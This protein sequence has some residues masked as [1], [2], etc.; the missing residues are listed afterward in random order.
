MRLGQVANRATRLTVGVLAAV[1]LALLVVPI[2]ALVLRAL[3][4]RGS[5][6][7]LLSQPLA[8]AVLLS[9]I[10]TSLSALLIVALG[11]PLAYVFARYRFPLKRVLN[12]LIEVPVVMPPV[13]AGLALLMTFGRRGVLGG[14]LAG[15][16]VSLPFSAAAVVIAQV[17]V[18]S[19]FFI[20]AAQVE[21]QSIPR[22]L[23]EAASIDGATGVQ[24][25]LHVI[26]PLS[27]RGLLVGLVLSWARAL[28][29]FGATILFAG[30]LQGR[31]QTMPLFVYGAM[32]RDLNAA[33]WASVMLIGVAVMALGV[34]RWL[35][36]SLEEPEGSTSRGS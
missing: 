26:L 36:R 7:A 17:F 16:G 25:F 6:P 35:S 27:A 32:E 3:A 28:G 19:P 33:L 30:N 5:L 10:T 11:M 24:T 15:A 14:V 4:G 1:M 22:E 13:V 2:A 34:M 23:E 12:V 8:D 21:F 18:A 29:E 20:R 9:L 31:T